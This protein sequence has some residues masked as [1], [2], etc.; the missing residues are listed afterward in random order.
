M[1]QT[2]T[3]LYFPPNPTTGTIFQADNGAQYLWD[4][5]KWISYVASGSSA[6]YWA[7]EL[8]TNSLTPIKI[9]E[10]IRLK[11]NST[12]ISLL[13]SASN[14]NVTAASGT[15]IFDS[16]ACKTLSVRSTVTNATTEVASINS[17]GLLTVTN[18]DMDAFPALPA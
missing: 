8:A 18:I 17:S 9:G 16:S 14:G 12:T 5:E 10:D 11:S 3:A 6:N 1:S 4:G 2:P 13:L 15:S 7:Q